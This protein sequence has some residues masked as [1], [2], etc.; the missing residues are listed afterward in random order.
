MLTGCLAS[1]LPKLMECR[2][3]IFASPS[4]DEMEVLIGS[5]ESTVSTHLERR[6]DGGEWIEK[7]S[8]NVT[9]R[10]LEDFL[11]FSM[12]ASIREDSLFVEGDVEELGL[13]ALFTLTVESREVERTKGSLFSGKEYSLARKPLVN[14]RLALINGLLVSS[15][16]S[17][18]EESGCINSLVGRV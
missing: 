3:E 1:F 10:R 8:S 16:G 7:S 12:R 4:R 11:D 6:L 17:S 18:T 14:T 13:A 5:V 9:S 15:F 2:E